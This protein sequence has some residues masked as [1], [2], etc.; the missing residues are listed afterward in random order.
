MYQWKG[1]SPSFQW[2]Y[3]AL[4]YMMTLLCNKASLINLYVFLKFIHYNFPLLPEAHHTEG[5]G[6]DRV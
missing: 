1:Q 2:G 4:P 5:Y 6:Y 3:T